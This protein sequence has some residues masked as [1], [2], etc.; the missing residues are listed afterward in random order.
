[1]RKKKDER[2][3]EAPDTTPESPYVAARR[4]WNERYGSYIARARNWRFAAIGSIGVSLLAVGGLIAV[5]LQSKI[6]PYVVELNGNHEVVRVQ[7]AD[8]M[9][10]AT[11]NQIRASLRNWIIGARSVYGDRLALKSLIDQTYA[12]TFPASPAFQQL[13]TYHR[14]NNPYTRAPNET[15]TVDV[16]AIVPVSDTTWQIEW[17]ETRKQASG[18]EIGSQRMQ[19]N[20]TVAVSPPQDD[21]QILVNPLGVY[22]Q[23]FAW[24]NRL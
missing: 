16:N 22:V 6:V 2:P 13:S 21:R 5:S 11:T 10:T 20:F 23:N 4:E 8:L 14:T 12:L 3:V 18:K 1:M 7:R 19:G 17:T 15:V 9:A 24:T